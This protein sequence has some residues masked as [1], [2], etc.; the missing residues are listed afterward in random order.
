M[1]STGV[2]KICK[3]ASALESVQTLCYPHG[4]YD[5][6]IHFKLV[7]GKNL[8]FRNRVYLK[9]ALYFFNHFFSTLFIAFYFFIK[10]IF[11]YKS[12]AT[13]LQE[14]WKTWSKVTYSSIIY[15]NYFL[16]R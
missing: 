6:K 15:Y 11:N 4:S 8:N 13:H 14:T 9:G 12:I 1:D 10:K 3:E 2:N 16:G 7:Q 5:F